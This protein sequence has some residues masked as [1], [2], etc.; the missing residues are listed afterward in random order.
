MPLTNGNDV[1]ASLHENGVNKFIKSLAL[2]R[3]HYFKFATAGLGGGSPAVGLLPPLTLP[4]A[5]YGLNYAIQI[6]PPQIDFFPQNVDLPPPLVL[7][8]NQFSV[9][10]GAHVCI[11][12]IAERMK[13]LKG[14]QLPPEKKGSG[15]KKPPSVPAPV[16]PDS[17]GKNL[18]CANL[19]VWAVGHPT[20]DPVSTTDKYVGL[21]V[22]EI[23]VKDV[24]GFEKIAECIAMDVLNALLEKARYL[25]KK[26]VFGAFGFFL[27]EGPRIEDDQLKV[28]G[29]I[30]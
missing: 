3:P 13:E 9:I 14:D 30:I 26:Q 29:G 20:V 25:V 23:V 11:D 16:P 17:T 18:L 22:D 2:A 15:D 12:C 5:G 6:E 21:A 24:G 4:G 19:K 1:F 10:T 7:A 28:W 27:A 8:R